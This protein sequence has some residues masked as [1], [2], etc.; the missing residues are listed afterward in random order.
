MYGTEEVWVVAKD[1]NMVVWY[2]D[3]EEDF[4]WAFVDVKGFI[5]EEGGGLVGNLGW[6]LT[7]TEFGK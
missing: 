4:G 3:V 7:A 2:C 5:E 1:G 6:V